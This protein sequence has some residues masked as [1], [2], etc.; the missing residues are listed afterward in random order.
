MS[1]VNPLIL[2]DIETISDDETISED[3][4][5]RLLV[6]D[7]DNNDEDEQVAFFT[8]HLSVSEIIY[9]AFPVEYPKT[10]PQGVATIFNVSGWSNPMAC[11]NDIQYSIYGSGGSIT[12]KDCP[13]F[14]V[15]VKKDVRKCQGIKHCSF[16]DADFLKEQHNEVDMESEVFIRLNQHHEKNNKRT[17]TY[18]FFLAT[19]SS[20]CKYK[21][22]N[23]LCNGQAKLRRMVKN[24][25]DEYFIGC[26]K[27]NKGEKW[28]RFIKVSE[29]IDLELLRDLFQGRGIN[30]S[31][32]EI[33]NDN[34]CYT[35]SPFASR[36]N[37]CDFPHIENGQV[38]R[39]TMV[40]QTCDVR[41]I[42]FIPHD[43][44]A[45]PYIA[46]ICIGT[47][48]HPPPPPERTPLG[49]KDEL[50][51]MIQNIIASDDSATPRNSVKATFDKDTLSEVHA[52]LNNVDKL[53]SLVAKCYQKM[54]P[55]G[56][57]NLG[58]LHSVQ[59]K[60]FDMHNYV[61]RIEHFENGQTLIICMLDLQ[62]KE[63]QKLKSFQIDLTFK[64]VH[65]DIN[66]FEINSYDNTHKLTE[67]YQRLFSRLFEVVENLSG[68]AVKFYHI[69][70]TGWECILGDLDAAQAKG[71]G[72]ALT[73]RDPSKNWEMHLTHIFKSC[74]V[75]FKRNLV[76]KKFNNEVYSLAV[77]IPSK[78]S[79]DEVH[80]IFEKLETYND[81]RVMDWIQYYQQT[82]VLASLNKHI[83]NMENE[84]WE[85]YGNNTN[86]AEAAHA[87]ANREGKQLKLITAI[88]RGRRLDE[89]LFKVAEVHNRF[90]VPYT[91]R[92]K[93]EIKRKSI[94]IS[95][96]S[97]RKEKEAKKETKKTVMSEITSQ[98]K[99]ITKRKSTIDDNVR[100][101]KNKIDDDDQE[102]SFEI[103]KQHT[104]LQIEIEERKMQLAERQTANRRALAEVEK[105][106]LEN[107]KLRKELEN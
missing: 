97:T 47:H 73:K 32:H 77:S 90:G 93:S 39:G 22:N 16:A 41:F 10:S 94:T 35:L 46:L 70:G 65:G 80:K 45:C 54:H 59:C 2:S 87:Q 96:K 21:T 1:K 88:M 107:I 82:Y 56:Q 69:D 74:L 29:E 27:W 25:G 4:S 92:D 51:T 62:A 75:H 100:R 40:K 31:N 36:T 11:F 71:L 101:K 48:N 95:R 72:L 86:T 63:L 17:K 24:T 8:K 38:V 99:P 89:R 60:K 14:G 26:D 91:R 67:A 37:F 83:S 68:I 50:Q 6:D 49:I 106:E 81:Q 104:I 3:E 76:A 23:Q 34:K 52:S 18:T 33:D 7:Q 98:E 61:R 5:S 19:Q 105:L 15:S 28:H 78:S 58:L 79:A 43:L 12:I 103:D 42:K 30:E 55:Y 57:G 102:N 84:I 44:V 9:S 85:N 13:F 53:R 64:R 20:T 66:E